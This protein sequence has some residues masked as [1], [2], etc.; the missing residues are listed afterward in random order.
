MITQNIELKHSCI[1]NSYLLSWLFKKQFSFK[2]MSDEIFQGCT[3]QTNSYTFLHLATSKSSILGR[4]FSK[5]Q[6]PCLTL[7]VERKPSLRIFSYETS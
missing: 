5:S 7:M 1:Y 2:P 3:E 6:I 4:T